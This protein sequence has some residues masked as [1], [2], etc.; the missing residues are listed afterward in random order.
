L[1]SFIVTYSLWGGFA[2]FAGIALFGVGVALTA[3]LA[4]LFNT[5]WEPFF[6]V[7]ILAALTY[8][9]RLAGYAIGNAVPANQGA[10]SK[11]GQ[12]DTEIDP[13]DLDPDCPAVAEFAARALQGARAGNETTVRALTAL[14]EAI[15]RFART[16]LPTCARCQTH[17]AFRRAKAEAIDV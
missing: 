7:I 13:A 2:V 14:G 11:L 4:S 8:G 6:T 5:M 16:H 15:P 3:V 9:S 1:Y 12:Q 10:G 17:Q